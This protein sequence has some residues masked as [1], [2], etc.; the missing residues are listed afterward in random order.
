MTLDQ[1]REEEMDEMNADDGCNKEE[2]TTKV[3]FSTDLAALMHLGR[4]GFQGASWRRGRMQVIWRRGIA[5][6]RGGWRREGWC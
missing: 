5:G 2:T 4:R 3:L 6:E 1:G